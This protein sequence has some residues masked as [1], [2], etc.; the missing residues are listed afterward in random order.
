MIS[1]SFVFC[2]QKST[3]QK[4]LS[5]W[6]ILYWKNISFLLFFGRFFAL[7]IAALILWPIGDFVVI[8]LLI[9][10]LGICV[11]MPKCCKQA[12]HFLLYY[13]IWY[14]DYIIFPRPNP[15]H[16]IFFYARKSMEMVIRARKKNKTFYGKK[17]MIFYFSQ[18]MFAYICTYTLELLFYARKS[19]KKLMW[20]EE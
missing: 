5:V 4:R 19:K 17:N 6:A 1:L 11:N 3:W 20:W 8:L 16:R 9:L 2:V 10:R 13:I 18:K 7:A 15:W 12:A 14:L